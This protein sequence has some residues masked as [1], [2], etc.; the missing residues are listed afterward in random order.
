[1]IDVNEY[2]DGKVKSL[3]LKTTTLPATVGVM[4]AGDYTFNTA[5]PEKITVVSGEMNIR[6]PGADDFTSYQ[7]GDSFEI[8]GGSAFDIKLSSDVAYLCLYG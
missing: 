4:L 7:A 1:M 8:P 6:H 2:F 5:E 3:S